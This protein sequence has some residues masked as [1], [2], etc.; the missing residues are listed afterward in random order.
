MAIDFNALNKNNA[1][2]RSAT[3]AADRP[4]AGVWV[5]IGYSVKVDVV[6]NGAV[7][8]Q[9]DR[10][11]SLPVG[12]PLDTTAPI[13]LKGS[14]EGYNAFVTARNDLMEQLMEFAKTL[15][16]GEDKMVDLQVQV[17]RVDEPAAPVAAANNPFAKK[18]S[19]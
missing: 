1:N 13:P 14:N 5:N 6:E 12:I 19:F 2:A 10:F 9:E 3:P 11:V 4:K 16:P 8:G 17:R 15:K 18:L 7:V